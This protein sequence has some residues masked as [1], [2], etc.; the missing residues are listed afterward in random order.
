M[1]AKEEV[2]ARLNIVDVIGEY[3]RLQRAGR[4]FR[5]LSPFTQEKTPSFFVSPDKQI[6]HC[7]STNKGGDVFSFIMEVEGMDFKE[8]LALLARKAGVELTQFQQGDGTA[9]KYR[10]RLYGLITLAS[11]YFQ[12]AMVQSKPAQSYIFEKRQLS[13][14]VVQ[15]FGIG[16]A[17]DSMNNLTQL[18]LQR[19]YSQRELIDAGLSAQRRS[20][21][22]DMFRARMMVPLRD[23]QGRVIGFTGRL[24][25][26][27]V[28]APKYLNTPATI[29]YDKSRHVFGLE[30]AKDA[31]RQVDYAVLVEG[32][33]DVVSSHQAG[34]R[35]VVATAGTAMTEFHLKTISRF[36]PHVR[37]CFD[38][39]R[40]GIAA[41]ERAIP[42]A[43]AVGVSLR[44]VELPD[45]V[46]DPDDLIKQDVTA[47]Q[48]CIDAAR[49]AVEW[50]IDEYVSRH[51]P[52]SA[53]GKTEI[54]TLA[55]RLV[56]QI[57][58]PVQ[59]EHYVNYL[60][61]KLAIPA[62][63]LHV[64]LQSIAHAPAEP[65]A[66]AQT[67]QLRLPPSAKDEYSYEDIFL[68]INTICPPARQSLALVDPANLHS[69]QRQRLYQQL[70]V[71]GE[72]DFKP[73]QLPEDETYG[74]ILLFKAEERYG[75][76]QW[77]P[78]SLITEARGLANII[79]T[80]TTKTKLKTISEAMQHAYELGDE[81]LLA[82]L[83]KQYQALMKQ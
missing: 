56:N 69:P 48:R 7:F 39:D 80:R 55:L 18:L 60:A 12:Q 77:D 72:A 68:A 53:N 1:D 10:E 23:P 76:S 26:D 31:L 37:L 44:V 9:A 78:D 46:K 3:V 38:R 57:D 82:E 67:K 29:L 40:A 65:T 32:N 2:R 79:N 74:K 83:T 45:G 73:D 51:D 21:L 16:Y 50:V 66:Q 15:D 8:A 70:T 6:W 30:L 62:G 13:K 81:A 64:K 58:D 5:G 52:T 42:M 71:L 61:G 27:E 17:P 35:Q 14:A 20:G 4:S 25:S 75:G 28:K 49:D 59:V 11:R 43:R 54:S 33:L 47:W 22:A 24:L 36:T 34:V 41:T 63:P 19:G